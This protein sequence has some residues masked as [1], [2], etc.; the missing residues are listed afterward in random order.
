M[1]PANI[2]FASAIIALAGI[3]FSYCKSNNTN[4]HTN[5]PAGFA[6][7]ELFTSEGCSSCPP[8]DEAMIRLAKEFPGHVYF[9]GYHVD[10]WDYIGWRDEFANADYTARQKKYSE[11]LNLTSIYTPQVIVN[12]KSELVGSR[13]SAIRSLI[14]QGLNDTASSVIEAE[15]IKVEGNQINFSYKTVTDAG[16]IF[17]IALVQLNA[18]TNVGRGENSGHKLNHI[19][20]V[21]NLMAHAI[22]KDDD[23]TGA[24]PIPKGLSAKDIKLIVF[25][26]D[27]NTLKITGA[28]ET[29]LK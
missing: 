22:G 13:E 15:N 8:A 11:T 5:K 16:C 12:G 10:Y 28:T 27:E 29:I 23:V 9:L 25:T 7:V 19:N 1:K 24:L 2:F 18:T 20:I 6:V 17:N 4:M 21:R 3:S 26:Q 14:Q